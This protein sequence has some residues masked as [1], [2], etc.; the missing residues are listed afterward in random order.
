MIHE[1]AG[2][3]KDSQS[4]QGLVQPYLDNLQMSW[5]ADVEDVYPIIGTASFVLMKEFPNTLSIVFTTPLAD[6]DE[7]V[8]ALKKTLK[9]WSSFRS[10][11]VE[12]DQATRLMVV[13]R[14]T[15]RYFDQAIS[16]HT[17]VEDEQALIGIS[18]SGNHAASELP[19]GLLFRTVVAKVKSTKTVGLIMLPNHAIID[20]VSFK[21]L[22]K[23][24]EAMITGALVT[25]RIPYKAFAET[26]YLHQTSRAAKIATDYH[27][28]RLRGIGSMRRALWPP[29]Y[30]INSVPTRAGVP[31]KKDVVETVEGGDYRNAQVTRYRH[32]PNLAATS[33]KRSTLINAAIAI[34]NTSITGSEH[35]IF[36]TLL[37][38]REWP[39]I[40]TSMAQLLP[41]PKTIAGPTLTA[42]VVVV[43]VDDAEPVSHFLGRLEVEQRLL[44]HHQHVP[45]DFPAHLEEADRQVWLL[46]QHR[47]ALNYQP[48]AEGFE[49]RTSSSSSSSAANSALRLVASSE[50]KVDRPNDAFGWECRF[51]DAETLR[52]QATFN[53]D[54][55]SQRQV[56][57]FTESVFDIVD[58]LSDTGN[59][60]KKVRDMRAIL[61]SEKESRL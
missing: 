4:T 14:A 38:G 36:M 58:F 55:F 13:L 39:F 50:Y 28:K 41:D 2:N 40:N 51:V 10:I 23:D 54:M 15:Q 49:V 42:T 47:Q 20:A 26:Y 3:R 29:S 21:A 6:P 7:L 60:G 19:R 34:F 18:T 24:L 17:D 25:K 46:A 48:N 57:R 56:I 53:P 61:L 35:A 9:S 52:I 30:L 45:L 16:I 27:V 33:E 59:G 37:A 5:E 8:A 44:R 22:R 32:C 43:G 11:A 12:Y 1:L 31:N